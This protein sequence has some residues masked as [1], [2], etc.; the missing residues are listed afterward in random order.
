MVST[1]SKHSLKQLSQPPRDT[2]EESNLQG[3]GSTRRNYQLCA[4][5]EGTL[6]GF[7]R[8]RSGS[9]KLSDDVE[10]L[11]IL[12]PEEEIQARAKV[13]VRNRGITQDNEKKRSKDVITISLSD[14]DEESMSPKINDVVEKNIE[15][16]SGNEEI[17]RVIKKGKQKVELVT[18]E[19]SNGSIKKSGFSV[20]KCKEVKKCKRQ[21]VPVPCI[22]WRTRSFRNQDR[23]RVMYTHCFGNV[24]DHFNS[25]MDTDI[26]DSDSISGLS[27]SEETK[28]E[29]NDSGSDS[30]DYSNSD[31]KS[32]FFESDEGAELAENRKRYED[33]S[34]TS[35]SVRPFGTDDWAPLLNKEARKEKDVVEAADGV[36]FSEDSEEVPILK[37]EKKIRR[38]RLHGEGCSRVQSLNK[39][40]WASPVELL[41]SSSDEL[42]E[43]M[44]EKEKRV[45]R[46]KR[47]G[48]LRRAKK[49]Q[50]KQP[51]KKDLLDYLMTIMDQGAEEALEGSE[52]EVHR[53]SPQELPLVF[54]WS[55]NEQMAEKSEF[56]NF[57]DEAWQDFDNA[58]AYEEVGTYNPTQV[59]SLSSE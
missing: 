13:G 24:K 29:E 34:M 47:V 3:G 43:K 37:R 2:D 12:S 35:N 56:E 39:D 14:S 26:S 7:D 45:E 50:E 4:T 16:E 41:V 30:D 18:A 55:D 40:N 1:H 42:N 20:R 11:E 44:C 38:H 53:N 22:A 27:E 46:E 32:S 59:L 36:A 10:I 57:V 9:N 54:D 28:H 23:E 48:G 31:T 33:G 58:L 51:T 49:K 17:K 8:S 21:N 25:P 6:N 15:V 52:S 19:S 5:S